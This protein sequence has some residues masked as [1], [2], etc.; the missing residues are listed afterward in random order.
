MQ[1][2]HAQSVVELVYLQNTTNNSIADI[3]YEDTSFTVVSVY[4]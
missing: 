1:R 4:V 2:N 3:L